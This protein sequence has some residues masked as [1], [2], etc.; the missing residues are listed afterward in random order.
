MT[1]IPKKLE[2]KY[3]DHKFLPDTSCE[4][5]P[6]NKELMEKI[7]KLID[8]LQAKEDKSYKVASSV[9]CDSSFRLEGDTKEGTMFH[10][11]N[12]CNK[13]C[14]TKL[15]EKKVEA[16][17]GECIHEGDRSNF[18]PQYC[19][20]CG[21]EFMYDNPPEHEEEYQD[22]A[23]LWGEKDAPDFHEVFKVVKSGYV[24]KEK[25]K[26]RYNRQRCAECKH[27]ECKELDKFM[28]SLGIGD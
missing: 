8:Y 17:K 28:K 15:T 25:I 13:A 23:K 10:V 9:C 6:T 5:P 24:S 1:N 20:K 3:Y 12:N 7:N 26:T 16:S 14:D 2:L 27:V 21:K 22:L 19:T 11:C 4:V 18:H